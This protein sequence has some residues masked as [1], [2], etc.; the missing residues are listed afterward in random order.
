MFS[1]GFLI[2]MIPVAIFGAVV[3]TRAEKERQAYEA[4]NPSQPVTS[5][6]PTQEIPPGAMRIN[7]EHRFGCSDREYFDRLG[8]IGG[9]GDEAALAD[10]IRMGYA[11]GVCVP[12]KAGEP[13][14]LEENQWGI[15]KVRRPSEQVGYWTFMEAAS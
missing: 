11:S 6:A 1:R 4:R 5:D 3:L 8:K 15:I 12:F 2:A 7:G 9:Q 14:Y 13:V 10:G